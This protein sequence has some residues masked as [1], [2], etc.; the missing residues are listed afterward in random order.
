MSKE[1]TV[2]LNE[3]QASKIL[4]LSIFTLR[5]WRAMRK[6]LE[7]SRP[8]GKS[9]RYNEKDVINFMNDARVECS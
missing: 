9:V 6:N 2:W 1:S 4:G 8:G 5:N 7:F 3:R